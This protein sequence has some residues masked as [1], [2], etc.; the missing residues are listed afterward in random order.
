MSKKIAIW[1]EVEFIED[2]N[3]NL[4]PTTHIV[5]FNQ[6][7][8][9]AHKYLPSPTQ[10]QVIYRGQRDA[11]WTL[12]SG[13]ERLIGKVPSKK[14]GEAV[15]KSFRMNIRGRLHF[16]AIGAEADMELWAIGQHF[17]LQTPLLDWSLSPYVALY[18]AFQ[19][20]APLGKGNRAV[21]L[22]NK[23]FIDDNS[24]DD[25][26]KTFEPRTDTQ[27]RLVS[28]A[29]L[30]T[31]SP[32]GDTFEQ[33]LLR[34]LDSTIKSEKKPRLHS[35]YFLKIL[36]PINSAIRT[37]II[38]NLRA[39]N[40]HAANIFP[41]ISGAASHTN[42]LIADKF[43]R[44]KLVDATKRLTQ[45]TGLAN[46]LKSTSAI[47]EIANRYN[48]DSEFRKIFSSSS[49]LVQAAEA[50][51]AISKLG[52][53]PN[54]VNVPKPNL[55]FQPVIPFQNLRIT[56]PN[57][58]LFESLSKITEQAS[59]VSAFFK[60]PIF[61]FYRSISDAVEKLKIPDDF[62]HIF[63]DKIDDLTEK[64][65][66]V[67]FIQSKKGQGK[68]RKSLQAVGFDKVRAAN[69]TRIVVDAATSLEENPDHPTPSKQ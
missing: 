16:E 12:R 59:Q 8:N 2:S 5:R 6:F 61:T 52:K 55:G 42:D 53:L 10:S 46:L 24:S 54:L 51:S 18:F 63:Y 66:W 29:G 30:F 3:G 65:D 28:Q 62:K 36:I 25:S 39:M 68:F 67:G 34:S 41:D 32:Y 69:L 40:I 15:L 19:Q 1:P 7:V 48:S 44:Q 35:L 37:E 21:Y 13:L 31:I 20:K 64:E 43:T 57:S 50:A 49:P 38:R 47:S 22:L 23:E 17:G 14:E 11:S 9:I 60:T 4:I 26:I 27:G 58:E 45:S 33:S 56:L